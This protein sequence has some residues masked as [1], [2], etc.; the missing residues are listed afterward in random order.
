MNV[1]EYLIEK[2]KADGYDGLFNA[3][4][5]CGCGLGDFIPCGK[6]PLWCEPGVYIQCAYS[7]FDFCIGPRKP[8]GQIGQ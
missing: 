3:D 5:E 1:K 6:S 7:D 4:E 2:L 8:K